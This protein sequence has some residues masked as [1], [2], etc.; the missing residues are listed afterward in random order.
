MLAR[1]ERPHHRRAALV[2][3]GLP[4]R[5]AADAPGRCLDS[6]FHASPAPT[7][8]PGGAAEAADPLR[9]SIQPEVIAIRRR[10]EELVLEL[11]M[12]A[13]AVV[14]DRE[15]HHLRPPAQCD[16]HMLGLGVTDHVEQRLRGDLDQRV[17]RT[18]GHRLG[19]TEDPQLDLEAGAGLDVLDHLAQRPREFDLPIADAAEDHLA[20]LVHHRARKALG[21][22]HPLEH[23]WRGHGVPAAPLQIDADRQQLLGHTLVQLA[24]EPVALL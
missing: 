19:L 13:R 20:N 21:S 9:D 8:E 17:L 12:V 23:H 14:R 16:P 4:L 6:Q 11:A 22:Y 7:L 18:G 2:E 24:P 15:R 1:H 5:N 10:V 3:P